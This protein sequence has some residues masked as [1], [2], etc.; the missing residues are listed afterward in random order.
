VVGPSQD[1]GYYLIGLSQWTPELFD[2]I[3]WGTEKVLELTLKKIHDLGLKC[4]MYFKMVFEMI[5]GKL[6]KKIEPDV[7]S[8]SIAFT[9]DVED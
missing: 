3:P 4:S 1:G 9:V 5:F 8:Q 6:Q 2:D 7:T